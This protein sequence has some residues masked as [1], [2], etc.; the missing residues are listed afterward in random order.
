[1]SENTSVGNVG[2]H[3]AGDQR[4]ASEAEKNENQA[5]RFEEG[6]ENSHKEQDS[7]KYILFDL[8]YWTISDFCLDPDS[9]RRG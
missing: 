4:N 3:G 7:S 2:V 1:M 5:E 9:R 8:Q 6:K